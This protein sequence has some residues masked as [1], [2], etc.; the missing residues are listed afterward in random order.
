MEKKKVGKG[1][2]GGPETDEPPLQ[3]RGKRRSLVS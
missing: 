1:G 2:Q 3:Q